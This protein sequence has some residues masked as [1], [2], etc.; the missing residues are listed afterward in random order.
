MS[1]VIPVRLEIVNASSAYSF[2]SKLSR[3]YPNEF[4]REQIWGDKDF[5]GKFNEKSRADFIRAHLDYCVDSGVTRAVNSHFEFV[6]TDENLSAFFALEKEGKMA[7]AKGFFAKFLEEDMLVTD[8]LRAFK[9]KRVA[10]GFEVRNFLE[11]N[12]KGQK[13]LKK[14]QRFFV[15]LLL[16][17][18]IILEYN[19]KGQEMIFDNEVLGRVKERQKLLTIGELQA[20][21]PTINLIKRESLSQPVNNHVVVLKSSQGE[22]KEYSVSFSDMLEI[23][24]IL[25]RRRGARQEE[26]G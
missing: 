19:M 11:A 15:N 25:E 8:F 23:A 5:F 24:G 2:I 22:I 7:D 16:Q 3:F 9:S 17:V 26:S 4:K 21:K 20:Q 13:S 18:G 14:A 12:L 1:S 10:K 6:T